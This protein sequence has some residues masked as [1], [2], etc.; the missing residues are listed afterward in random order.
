MLNKIS[1]VC[2]L[3]YPQI[4]LFYWL[5][6]LQDIDSWSFLGEAQFIES[7]LNVSLILQINE[8]HFQAKFDAYLLIYLLGH[9]EYNGYTIHKLTQWLLTADGVI[10]WDS[11][12][13]CM[14]GCQVTSRMHNQFSKYSKLLDFFQTLCIYLH[15]W[16]FT[17]QHFLC[18]NWQNLWLLL[19][20]L[21]WK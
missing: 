20:L 19:F 7:S 13:S 9:C 8:C 17:L 11:V 15:F 6:V 12:C 10:P 16:E 2:T 14:I 4:F 1:M 18:D 3:W 5:K 21:N